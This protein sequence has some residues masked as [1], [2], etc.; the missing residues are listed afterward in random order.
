MQLSTEGLD[1]TGY[2]PLR[3]SVLVGAYD[4]CFGHVE[5]VASLGVVLRLVKR[6]AWPVLCTQAFNEP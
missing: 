4:D 3:K 6:F 1:K 5:A 2:V